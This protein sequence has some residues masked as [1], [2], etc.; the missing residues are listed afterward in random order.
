[1]DVD[2]VAFDIDGTLYPNR[3]MYFNSALFSLSRLRFLNHYRK[4]RK[5]IRQ[6]RPIKDFK[7]TQA[8][9]LSENMNISL[10][11]AFQKIDS[12]IYRKWQKTFKRVRT[13]THLVEILKK[14]HHNGYKLGVMS[15]F[16]IGGKLEYLGLSGVWDCIISSEDTGYLKP[17][18]EP[19]YAVSSCLGLRSDRI[20]YV[21]NNY[22]YDIIGAYRVGMKTAHLAREPA[23]NSVADLTFRDYR[24][25]ET[26]LI[27]VP[28]S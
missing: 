28:K 21:G 23:E 6:I 27:G 4:V 15:D 14:L 22:D 16:P 20:L 12:D 5:T 13:Y 8:R 26:A 10:E 2:A 11:H 7:S 9:L 24:E 18:P 3:Q 25:L 1:M 19:F 17:N